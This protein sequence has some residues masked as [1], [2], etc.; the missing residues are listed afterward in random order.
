MDCSLDWSKL[1]VGP[2]S[3]GLNQDILRASS[4][5]LVVSFTI[6]HS[7]NS[8]LALQFHISIDWV[9]FG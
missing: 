4:V 6:F 7:F 8:V 5:G 1:D 9:D 2:I 3:V